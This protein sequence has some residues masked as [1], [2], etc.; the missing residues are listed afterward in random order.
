MMPQNPVQG[1]NSMTRFS[2][3]SVL[4]TASLFALSLGVGAALAAGEPDPPGSRSPGP[5]STQKPASGQKETTGAKK[6]QKKSEQEFLD[7]YRA[8]YALKLAGNYEEAF[9]AFKALDADD[10]PDVATELGYAARKLGDYQ[11]SKYWYEHA[12]AID[13]QHVKTWQYY[14][15]WQVEQGNMLKAGD[16][17]EKIRLICGT[18]CREYQDLKGGMEGTVSY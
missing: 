5:S 17:L 6:K 2:R 10:H 12:L 1:G 8:A 9:A 13:P 11:L 7:Q 4:T 18:E 3:L 16:M 14:G 15:M